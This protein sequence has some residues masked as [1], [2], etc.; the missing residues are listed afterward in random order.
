MF[1]HLLSEIRAAR[2]E[3]EDQVEVF[4]HTLQESIVECVARGCLSLDGVSLVLQVGQLVHD[5][6]FLFFVL[7]ARFLLLASQSLL[8]LLLLLLDGYEGLQDVALPSDLGAYV[9]L[10]K[11]LQVLEPSVTRD[12]V[13][14]TNICQRFV[15]HR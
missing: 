7:L 1:V 12:A 15:F 13:L 5:L 11:G 14:V 10:D 2:S 4:P 8:R 6:F 3:V 9:A